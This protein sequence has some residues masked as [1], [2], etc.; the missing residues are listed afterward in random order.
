MSSPTRLLSE[1][2]RISC[3]CA[4][5]TRGCLARLRRRSARPAF[6]CAR[7]QACCRSRGGSRSTHELSTM[8]AMRPACLSR[9]AREDAL[10]LCVA[11]ACELSRTAVSHARPPERPLSNKDAQLADQYQNRAPAGCAVRGYQAK[12]FACIHW[13]TPCTLSSSPKGAHAAGHVKSSF[14]CMS[15]WPHVRT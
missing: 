9:T 8:P 2:S 1:K 7:S 13:P 14:I 4:L 3:T 6:A 11:L 10:E 15:A 12:T 5:R